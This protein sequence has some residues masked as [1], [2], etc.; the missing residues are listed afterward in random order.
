MLLGLRDADAIACITHGFKRNSAAAASQLNP[1]DAVFRMA[2]DMSGCFTSSRALVSASGSPSRINTNQVALVSQQQHHHQQQQQQQQQHQQQQSAVST[3]ET[4][5]Q[6]PASAVD[7]PCTSPSAALHSPACNHSSHLSLDPDD[8]AAMS[9]LVD[10]LARAKLV[11]ADRRPDFAVKLLG[12]G[13]CDEQ[14]LRDSLSA[15]PPDF[16][17]VQDIGMTGAQQRCLLKFLKDLDV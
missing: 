16:D 12:Q 13:V 11:P 14:S 5:A 9:C 2:A 17:L 1:V 3:T 7:V 10:L 8:A 6:D 15:S 4:S